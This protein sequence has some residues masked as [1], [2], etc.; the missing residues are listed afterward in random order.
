ML[1][2]PDAPVTMHEYSSFTCSACM[3]F[4]DSS[5]F[6]LLEDIEAGSVNVV[7]VPVAQ[8]QQDVLAN[9]AAFCAI[10]QGSFWEMHDTLFSW[11]ALYGAAAFDT[12]RFSPAAETLSLDIGA[13]LTCLGDSETDDRLI[14]AN[15]LWETMTTQYGINQATPT[16]TFNGVPSASGS[17]ALS[18]AAIRNEINNALTQ[19]GR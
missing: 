19:A 8:I 12:R 1:G 2:D 10:E 11:Q 4:H 9:R 18:I 17:G 5:F 7:Y 3:N 16:L 6:S 14:E 13:F 15:N